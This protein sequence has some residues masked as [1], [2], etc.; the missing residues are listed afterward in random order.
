VLFTAKTTP[1]RYDKV[2]FTFGQLLYILVIDTSC[3]KEETMS[4]TQHR[5]QELRQRGFRMTPQRQVILQI[6]HDANG[7][8][9]PVD[10]FT[11]A[12]QRFPGLT[13][14]TVYRTL[15]FLVQNGMIH[16]T[17]NPGGHLVYEITG[18]EHHHLICLNCNNS[19]EIAHSALY[20]LYKKLEV[21]SGFQLNSSHLTFF[22]LCRDCQSNPK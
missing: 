22:G 19:I 11:S 7:H 12:S 8:L 18:H 4:C 6:L 20:D 9:S 2:V 3:N 15:D 5:T 16:S 21:D 1:Y 13:E 17:H 14:T 10:I